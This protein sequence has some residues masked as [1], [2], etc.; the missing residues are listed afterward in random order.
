MLLPERCP[1]SSSDSGA[2]TSMRAYVPPARMQASSALGASPRIRRT[3]RCGL[4]NRPAEAGGFDV[5]AASPS[6]RAIEGSARWGDAPRPHGESPALLAKL[7][8][9][10]PP[11]R[12]PLTPPVRALGATPCP[13]ESALV[14]LAS[15][16]VCYSACVKRACF[17]LLATFWSACSSGDVCIPGQQIAC[18]CGG[19]EEGFQVC[20]AD[21]KSL[22]SCECGNGGSG[23]SGGGGTGG[24]QGGAGGGGAGGT[25][26][27]AGGGTVCNPGEMASCYDGPPATL[28][29]G[30]CKAG[31]QQC[32]LDG[33]SYGPCTGQVLPAVEDCASPGDENCDGLEAP[34]DSWLVTFGVD[35]G[36][37]STYGLRLGVDPLGNVFVAGTFDGSITFAGT[38]VFSVG[39]FDVFVAK[40]ASDGTEQWIRTLA[41]T[42]GDE[43]LAL[44]VDSVG[45]V[46]IGGPFYG[47]LDVAG[48]ASLVSAGNADGYVAVF[49]GDGDL[50]W[51]KRYGGALYDAVYGLGFDAANHLR[52]VG[53][54]QSGAPFG[55]LPLPAGLAYAELDPSGAGVSSK[56]FAVSNTPFH[57][58]AVEPSGESLITGPMSPQ[59]TIDFGGLVLGPSPGAGTNLTFYARLD[60]TGAPVFGGTLTGPSDVSPSA[61]ES[62]AA[63]GLLLAGHYYQN[64][65]FGPGP[66]F[67]PTPVNPFVWWAWMARVDDTG[68]V[69]WAFPVVGGQQTN[70]FDLAWGPGGTLLAPGTFDTTADFGGG[71]LSSSGNRD[72]S[73][74]RVDPAN[75]SDA[76]SFAFGASGDDQAYA[77]AATPDGAVVLSGSYTTGGWDSGAGVVPIAASFST[78][79]FVVKRALP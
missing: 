38:T 58:F 62:D 10:V 75:G 31:T 9:L 13:T 14:V 26:G 16:V 33:L 44:S 76:G 73:V 70:V 11:P 66:A 34:C 24:A 18:A 49:E 78:K 7:A 29:V 55:G 60:A 52:L 6:A 21:G 41:T 12:Y 50:A 30:I 77:A 40:I 36:A 48:A 47:T 42:G 43:V 72:C 57:L 56:S 54:N 35:Q 1:S 61:I 69:Q 65:D 27:G 15:R 67:P 46:A 45:R 74:G 23:G 17:L 32:Q 68:A 2:S 4:E 59:D 51:A 37:F 3:P 79:T 53:P 71:A 63:G 39:Q 22:G 20:A 8:A 28:G 19:G 5:H 64:P 25:A